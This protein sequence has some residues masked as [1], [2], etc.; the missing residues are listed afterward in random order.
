MNWD[1]DNPAVTYLQ[2]ICLSFTFASI[3][4]LLI[5]IGLYLIGFRL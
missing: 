4:F 5:C 3:G 2:D 1:W